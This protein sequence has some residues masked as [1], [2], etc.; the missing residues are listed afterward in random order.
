MSKYVLAMCCLIISMCFYFKP[1]F[2]TNNTNVIFGLIF[3]LLANLFFNY[4]RED[5]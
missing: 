1:D 2:L 4:K 5:R 3:M